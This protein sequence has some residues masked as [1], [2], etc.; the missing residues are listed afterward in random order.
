MFAG[1]VVDVPPLLKS[2]LDSDYL[3]LHGQRSYPRL[4]G[5]LTGDPR[6]RVVHAGPNLLLE[7]RE[8]A[9]HFLLDWDVSAPGSPPVRY[10]RSGRPLEAFVELPRVA[11][12]G[13]CRTFTA[14][15]ACSVC[16]LRLRA[17]GRAT[18]RSDG[19]VVARVDSPGL[20]DWIEVAPEPRSSLA[21]ELCGSPFAGFF[22][23]APNAGRTHPV[24]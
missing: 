4:R 10:P 14:N 20:S 16:A 7:A 18:L 17:V 12:D 9:G 13:S 2:A 1:R 22:L 6:W 24:G 11:R 5:V 8:P 21:V 23:Y 3:A 15:D 19:R